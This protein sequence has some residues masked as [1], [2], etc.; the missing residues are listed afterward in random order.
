MKKLL[1]N[2][3]VDFEEAC[4]FQYGE[5]EC[6]PTC[7]NVPWTTVISMCVDYKL[8]SIDLVDPDSAK[9]CIFMLYLQLAVFLYI[10]HSTSVFSLTS[11]S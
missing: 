6:Q 7:Y 4:N 11:N 3:E 2:L 9:V 8:D 10:L 1:H 5:T